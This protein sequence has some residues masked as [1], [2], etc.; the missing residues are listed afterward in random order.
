MKIKFTEQSLISLQ[1]S[2]DFI[3]QEISLEKLIKIKNQLLD[4]TDILIAHPKL[5]KK[6]AYLEH[7]NLEHRSIIEGHYKVVYRIEKKII[8]ITDIFDTRQNP[9]KMK[10]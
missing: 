4:A 10:G 6:E 2:L 7:L 5:G 8:Y 3:S 9:K 1:E